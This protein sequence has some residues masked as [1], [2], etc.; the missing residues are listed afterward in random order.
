M[1]R[2]ARY[3]YRAQRHLSPEF[4]G[5]RVMLTMFPFR[6]TNCRACIARDGVGDGGATALCLATACERTELLLPEEAKPLM[7]G[8]EP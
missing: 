2:A 6:I 4:K 1:T 7:K 3:T 5:L 8:E